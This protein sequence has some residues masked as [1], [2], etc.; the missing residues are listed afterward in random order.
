M[1]SPLAELLRPAQTNLQ[2][3]EQLGR[4]GRS[5]TE[6]VA[7]HR[8]YQLIMHLFV[9]Q[10]RANGK[11]FIAHLVGTAGIL[12][13]LGERTE[14][15]IAGLL[16]AAYTHGQFHGGQH[17]LASRKRAAVRAAAGDEVEAL[18][19]RY[20]TF[21]W[22]PE[23]T[24]QIQRDFETLSALDRNILTIRLANELEDRL[25]R[26]LCYFASGDRDQLNGADVELAERSGHPELAAALRRVHDDA[27]ACDVP[28]D[29][30]SERCASF[31]IA[32]AMYRLLEPL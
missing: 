5:R 25:D 10:Y 6:L 24:N 32:P 14:V 11:P 31:T 16:H 7:V 20:S 12:V 21:A 23:A 15:V 29:L 30:K 27:A 8:A 28:P 4:S 2:L 1:A 9:G 18:V 26:G 3:Y 19:L 13:L 22:D 17:C